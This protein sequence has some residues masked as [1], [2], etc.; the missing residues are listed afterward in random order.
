MYRVPT[1]KNIKSKVDVTSIQETHVSAVAFCL[2]YAYGEPGILID[3]EW[4]GA[5]VVVMKH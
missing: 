3:V 2:N 5:T 1:G 4:K